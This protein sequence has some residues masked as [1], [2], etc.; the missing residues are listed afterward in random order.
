MGETASTFTTA[1]GYITGAMGD[2][3][4]TIE[5][6]ALMLV[7]IAGSVAAAGLG[8]VKSATGQRRGRRR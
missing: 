6:H 1:M 7:G 4:D 8:L 2:M 3:T 5:Q